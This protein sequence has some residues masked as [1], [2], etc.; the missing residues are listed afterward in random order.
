MMSFMSLMADYVRVHL[1][2]ASITERKQAL[3]MYYCAHA[4]VNGKKV[5]PAMT[6]VGIHNA[7]SA[8]FA[9]LVSS[10]A[11][12]MFLDHFVRHCS[13]STIFARVYLCSAA[14]E[15]NAK[16]VFRLADFWVRIV[17]CFFFYAQFSPVV[18][19]VAVN[20]VRNER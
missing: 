4:T 7:I 8:V 18:V 19:F 11:H 6:K 17:A 20:V 13:P 12:E 1:V 2:V 15:E 10:P 16:P 9:A 5:T 14:L 3:G